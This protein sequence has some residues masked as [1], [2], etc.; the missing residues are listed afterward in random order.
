MTLSE[1]AAGSLN[2]AAL[3]L[4]VLAEGPRQGLSIKELCARTE[5]PR[6]TVYRVLDLLLAL[7]WVV[8]E[9]DTSLINLGPELAALGYAAASR[10]PLERIAA[11]E[12]ALLAR[13]LD[14]TVYLDL[15]SSLDMVCVGR[16]E[17]ASQIQVGR[18][19]VGMRGPLGMTPGGM[20]VLARLPAAERQKIVT[21]NM[22]RY[23]TLEGFDEA[24]FESSLEHSVSLGYGRYDAIIL[25][26]T[27]CGLGVA[28][29]DAEARPFASIGVAFM[30]GW[31]SAK[32]LKDWV[33]DLTKT[34]ER[35]SALVY[36][37]PPA[38]T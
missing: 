30:K 20:A 5:L 21:A 13:R 16:Y 22:D 14:Q 33:S 7:E 19:W 3:I 36:S 17:G 10:F 15:R 27:M 9:R 28:I 2:R 26:R 4:R 29:C 23:R 1:N 31:L 6:P 35:I 38:H 18:G 34:S 37:V 24:G 11:T 8:R 12:L 25:D 32:Q